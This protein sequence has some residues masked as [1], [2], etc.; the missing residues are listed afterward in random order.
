MF[1]RGL[2]IDFTR[3][4]RRGRY[5]ATDAI[6][7]PKLEP[8]TVRKQFIVPSIGS[9]EVARIHRSG[10][11]HGENPLE[12]FDFGNGLFRIH[13]SL[14]SSREHKSVKQYSRSRTRAVWCRPMTIAASRTPP[15]L[16]SRWG[17]Q[18]RRLSRE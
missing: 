11:R 1:P 12:P 7:L 2:A 9:C 16:V 15:W 3:A 17:C 8:R 6:S 4:E 5:P 18:D 13:S 14:S 10:I